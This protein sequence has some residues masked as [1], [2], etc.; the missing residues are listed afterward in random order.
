MYKGF[1]DHSSHNSGKAKC[2]SVS[3]FHSVGSDT[4]KVYKRTALPKD[5]LDLGSPLE[6]CGTK[7]KSDEMLFDTIDQGR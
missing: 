4:S 3:Q 2:Q 1:H 6:V 5:W 7:R